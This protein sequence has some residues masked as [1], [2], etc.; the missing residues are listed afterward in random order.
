LAPAQIHFCIAP[1]NE[2]APAVPPYNV[3]K[4][5]FSQKPIVIAAASLILPPVG[6]ILLWMRKGT[7]VFRKCLCSLA[8]VAVAVAQLFLVY[9]MHVQLSGGFRPLVS[10]Q[11]VERHYQQL[12]AQR[13]S[14]PAAPPSTGSTYWADFMG[15]GRLGHYDQRPILTQWPAAGLQRVWKQ[16]VGGGYASFT[17]ANG[18]AF[19]IEQRRGNEVVAAYDVHTGRER[20]TNS[21]KALF[22]EV[23]GGNGPRA[24]PVW[25]DGRVYALGA[26]GELRCLDAATG[27]SIWNK[28]ILSDNAATNIQ[29]GMS[30]SPLIVDGK[31]IVTPGGRHGNSVV[32]YDKLTGQ[33]VWGSLD[34]KAAY[35]SPTV[36]IVGGR[37]QLLVMTATR[38]VGLTV[39]DGKL[40]W[41]YPWVTQSDIN[42]AQPIAVSD[43]RVYISS[44]YGHGAAVLELT[45]RGDAL[46]TRVVW[47]NTRMKNKFNSAVLYQGNIYGL[48]EGILACVDAESGALKWKGGRYGYGQLLLSTGHLVVLTEEGDVV[49][50]RAAPE[51]HQELA[52]FSAITGKT[53]NVPAISDGLLLVRNETEMAAFR[54]AAN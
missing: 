40:L 14:I 4:M 39:E 45:P 11:N 9:G 18:L 32:A 20:W 33:R 24:T 48:D 19:T 46:Q 43:N 15:P 52:R 5:R 53:W 16:P 35:A 26:T 44:G 30:A 47:T 23:L 21:W 36:A 54:I 38:A 17:V 7:G 2:T 22:E 28:N 51:Q 34:D 3:N 8:I 31:V 27:N 10:F 6:L 42:A 29:W 50:V 13:A 41:E 49:L 37:R 1:P 25:D 12:E